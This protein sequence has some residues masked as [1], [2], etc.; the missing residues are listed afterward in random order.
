[1][2]ISVS[3]F[4]TFLCSF[5]FHL[6]LLRGGWR[7]PFLFSAARQRLLQALK[8]DGESNHQDR[9]RTPLPLSSVLHLEDQY[10]STGTWLWT[11]FGRAGSSLNSSR[12]ASSGRSCPSC[13]YPAR[14]RK[15]AAASQ[16]VVTSS[17]FGPRAQSFRLV[18]QHC[19]SRHTQVWDIR[20]PAARPRGA[21]AALLLAVGPDFLLLRVLQAAPRNRRAGASRA[22]R[23]QATHDRDHDQPSPDPDFLLAYELRPRRPV[24]VAGLD[25]PSTSHGARHRPRRPGRVPRGLPGRSSPPQQQAR[26]AQTDAARTPPHHGSRAPHSTG[27]RCR[28]RGRDRESARWCRSIFIEEYVYGGQL[29]PAT[30]GPPA[31]E[32]DLCPGPGRASTAGVGRAAAAAAR[33]RCPQLC[34]GF[35]LCFGLCIWLCI[36]LCFWLCF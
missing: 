19:G 6:F 32:L 16:A 23:D 7:P 21:A 14:C 10:V 11:R 2:S 31:G 28:A 36:W 35:G 17:G 25:T 8:S 1:M 30:A 13:A 5:I 26:W 15:L 29:P 12:V 9:F 4:T 24:R 20:L 33:S 18:S 27:L 3:P 34:N 22:D